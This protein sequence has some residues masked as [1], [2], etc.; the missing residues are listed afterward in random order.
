MKLNEKDIIKLL[1]KHDPISLCDEN[2]PDEYEAEAR[3]IVEKLQDAKS[4]DDVTLIIWKTFQEM[5][6]ADIA[7]EKKRYEAIAKDIWKS[8]S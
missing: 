6:S 4:E 8:L 7:G 1:Y 2:N 5:F 3:M